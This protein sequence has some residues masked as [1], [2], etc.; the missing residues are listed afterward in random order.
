MPKEL[1]LFTQEFP[2]G[3][4]ETFLENELPVL[5]EG[6][7]RIRLFP[8][9]SGGTPRPL[10]P[11]VMV[12]DVFNRM[13]AFRPITAWRLLLNLP[14]AWKVYRSGRTSAPSKA[15]FLKHRKEYFSQLRQAMER[16][17]LFHKRK[18]A[19]YDAASVVLYSFWTADWATVLGFW[20][21]RDSSVK[22]VSR[23]MGFDLFDHRAVEG[24]HRFQAFHVRMVE[25][26]YVNG[27]AGLR[28]IQ[29][30]FPQLKD[31]FSL[32][33]LATSDHGT[34]AWEPASALRIVSCSNLVE[35]KRVHLIAEA[36]HHVNGPVQWDHFGDGPEL[37]RI[38]DVVKTLPPTAQVNLHG[39]IPN[40]EV[41]SWYKRHPVDVFVHASRTEGLP[42]AIQEAASFG[43]PLVAADA[44]GVAEVVTPE[45]GIL[46]PNQLTG[47]ELGDVL[48]KFKGSTWYAPEARH[49]VRAFW[50][51]KFEARMVYGDLMQKLLRQ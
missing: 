25:H 28:H 27:N 36:L 34:V 23:M 32:S 17:R 18:G 15:V 14:K 43:I 49:R 16:E 51:G 3:A 40:A 44:G 11:G 45:S 9:F 33:Y 29:K 26:V 24:W 10:P 31:R 48:G 35:L 50:Q 19:S 30:R 6:F 47:A 46:L 21:L 39:R 13:E 22:F 42:V 2:Y 20:K 12:E 1:W 4:G 37:G 41:I 38:M 5:V 8:M 7:S